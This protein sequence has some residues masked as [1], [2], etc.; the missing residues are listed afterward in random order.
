[1]T[2]TVVEPVQVSTP[3]PAA[4]ATTA[5]IAAVRADVAAL[6]ATV[7]GTVPRKVGA[8]VKAATAKV[9]AKVP[10]GNVAKMVYGVAGGAA[11]AIQFAPHVATVLKAVTGWL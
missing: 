1:M 4:P 8:V 10:T 11:G 5:D 9:T 2:G 6:H 3:A 7:T